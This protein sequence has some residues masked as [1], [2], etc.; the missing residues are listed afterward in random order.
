MS[1]KKIDEGFQVND[2]INEK[3]VIANQLGSGGMGLVYL[4]HDL[5]NM[6]RRVVI[7]T[8]KQEAL[9]NTYVVKHFLQE[10]EALGRINHDGV[11]RM[12]EN[13]ADKKTGLPFIAMEFADGY[14][15]TKVIERELMDAKKCAHIVN[16]IAYALTAAHDKDVLHRDLKPDNIIVIESQH[17]SDKIKLI[18]FGIAKVKESSVGPSTAVEVLV[19][20]PEYLSPEQLN[21]DQT[22]QGEVFSLAVVAYQMLTQKLAF[23]LSGYRERNEK[24]SKL[25]ELHR[26]GPKSPLK[27]RRD[28]PN[29]VEKVLLKGMELNPDKRYK[30]P[31]EFAKALTIALENKVIQAPDVRYR[32]RPRWQ[33]VIRRNL[34]PLIALFC[35]LAVAIYL[36]L[37]RQPSTT[38]TQ[39]HLSSSTSRN[40]Q[41]SSW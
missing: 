27:I 4:A 7:K 36:F 11:V 13:E 32:V 39:K 37:S 33:K 9:G 1:T 28:L 34:W 26:K 20:T 29:A 18:D 21:F 35:L 30:T 16:Q 40:S 41:A 12:I 23:P 3:Y 5:N 2:I 8:L 15:L 22:I 10:A 17:E 31:I 14:T 6:R 19:G 24:I 38:K 25:R